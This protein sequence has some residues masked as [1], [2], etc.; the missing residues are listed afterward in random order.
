M[1]QFFL[2]DIINVFDM[3]KN[4]GWNEPSDQFCYLFVWYESICQYMILTFY[5]LKSV[6]SYYRHCYLHIIL[7]LLRSWNIALQYLNIFL[8]SLHTIHQLQT[9]L[10]LQWIQRLGLLWLWL[11]ELEQ[12]WIMNIA[13]RVLT[14]TV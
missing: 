13:C 1:P 10:Q 11:D 4:D 9:T 2:T 7:P 8:S 14:T 6:S 12:I 5:F 3:E